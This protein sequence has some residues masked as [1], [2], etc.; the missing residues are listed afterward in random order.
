MA[1]NSN[2][3]WTD[4]SWN[5]LAGCE[6]IS[7]GCANCY[8]ATM[9]RRLE[10]M[11]QKD[12]AGLTTA[13]HFNGKVRCLP[14]KLDIPLKWKKTRRVFVNSM[15]DLFH[16]DVP[17]EFIVKCFAVMLLTQRHTY[18]ILTKRPQRMRRIVAAPNF[19]ECVYDMAFDLSH[20][21]TCGGLIDGVPET[22]VLPN[23]WLGVSVEDQQRAGERIPLLLQT[24]AAVRFLSCEPLLGPVDILH[25]LKMIRWPDGRVSSYIHGSDGPR[26][27]PWVIAGGESGSH[28]RPCNVAWIRS[29]VQQCKS[30]GVAAFVKQLGSRPYTSQSVFTGPG[31]IYTLEHADGG[32]VE[33]HPS[34]KKGGNIEEFPADLRVRE[35]PTVGGS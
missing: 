16:E 22:D 15:S 24:P 33:H 12:Y 13:K 1:T 23:V 6:A 21:W 31:D 4:A 17:D 9:T 10:A 35:F 5:C 26:M 18:Q 3:E 20:N 29:I 30:A 25:F 27:I 28:A 32:R 7:P 14:D 19:G 2:I 11:G 8:A 34:D